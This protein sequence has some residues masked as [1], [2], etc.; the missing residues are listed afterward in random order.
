MS[1]SKLHHMSILGQW[2]RVRL[3]CIHKRFK[4]NHDAEYL[5]IIFVAAIT[6]QI[7]KTSGDKHIIISNIK[8]LE[9][10]MHMINIPY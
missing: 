10:D 4:A 7:K 3:L 8:L 1:D 6:T 9:L 5:S 2:T